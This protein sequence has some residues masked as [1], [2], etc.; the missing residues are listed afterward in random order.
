MRLTDLM[1]KEI[2]NLHDGSRL[3][4]LGEAE[5][6]L[7]TSEG[8]VKAII[9]PIR[10]GRLSFLGGR[11]EL[12]IPWEAVKKIGSEVVI[13]NMDPTYSRRKD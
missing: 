8:T 9:M 10:S 1:G 7:D 6:L 3:G 4:N 5:L 12:V 11:Q 13:V 2:I